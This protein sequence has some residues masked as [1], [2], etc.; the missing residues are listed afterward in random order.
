MLH[1]KLIPI[2]AALLFSSTLMSQTSDSLDLV[3]KR[4]AEAGLI[5]E[6]DFEDI[7]RTESIRSSVAEGPFPIKFPEDALLLWLMDKVPLGQKDELTQDQTETYIAQLKKAGLMSALVEHKWQN[8]IL[9]DSIALGRRTILSRIFT[10]RGI[11]NLFYGPPFQ[12]FLN[13]F[14]QKHPINQ[15][16]LGRLQSK[17]K[18]HEDLTGDDLLDFLPMPAV[19]LPTDETSEAIEVYYRQ[20]AALIP[21]VKNAD[22]SVVKS[23]ESLV[24]GFKVL[25][26]QYE[27]TVR[28]QK[29]QIVYYPGQ[30]FL[31]SIHENL[32]LTAFNDALAALGSDQR[33]VYGSSIAA[34]LWTEP[35]PCHA[36][37]ISAAAFKALQQTPEQAEKTLSFLFFYPQQFPETP[38]PYNAWIQKWQ[39]NNLITSEEALGSG[40]LFEYLEVNKSGIFPG[41]SSNVSNE[42][43]ALTFIKSSYSNRQ[44]PPKQVE[45]EAFKQAVTEYFQKMVTAGIVSE[46]LAETFN[47]QI[48]KGISNNQQFPPDIWT[49]LWAVIRISNEQVVQSN[50]IQILIETAK[51]RGIFSPQCTPADLMSLS[52]FLENGLNPTFQRYQTPVLKSFSDT[53]VFRQAVRSFFDTLKIWFP[54]AKFDSLQ[55][56]VTTDTSEPKVP[57]YGVRWTQEGR[58]SRQQILEYK[59]IPGIYSDAPYFFEECWEHIATSMQF[60]CSN[61]R[62]LINGQRLEPLGFLSEVPY[63]TERVGF[64]LVLAPHEVVVWLRSQYKVLKTLPFH[65]QGWD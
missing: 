8:A 65:I 32:P 21:E 51:Q 40:V 59:Q 18:Q 31:Q 58:L 55:F 9:K 1:L 12:T 63:T 24:F 62:R 11:E 37:L 33:L 60:S 2:L 42:L 39:Q 61:I 13:D 49:L 14:T 57:I 50:D 26:K 7:R 20:L 25:D 48:S 27:Q 64:T 17:I 5:Q 15:A 54:A 23:R 43:V 53:L 44:A 41:I 22:I 45:T 3:L 34:L 16:G 29:N 35:P 38:S 52:T 36:L 4:A 30:R 47:A 6:K 56:Y 46:A 28:L 19:R 10:F